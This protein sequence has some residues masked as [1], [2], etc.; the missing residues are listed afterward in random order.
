MNDPGMIREISTVEYDH[1]FRP[2]VEIVCDYSVHTL[3][4]RRFTSADDIFLASDAHM[5]LLR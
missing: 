4:R 1:R 5:S 3:F 2:S